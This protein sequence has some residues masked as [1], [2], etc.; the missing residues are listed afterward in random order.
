MNISALAPSTGSARSFGVKA[1]SDAK[2]A[3]R[4]FSMKRMKTIRLSTTAAA[5]LLATTFGATVVL[6]QSSPP[7]PSPQA[8]EPGQG[9]MGKGGMDHGG[10]MDM[11]QR[12]RMIENCNR[13]MQSREQSPSHQQDAKPDHG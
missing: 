6:A 5:A 7:T 8:P 12:N 4:N 10:M 9:M 3:E 11:S 2:T 1:V 13:M